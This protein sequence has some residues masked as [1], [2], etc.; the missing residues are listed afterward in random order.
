M[1]SL[2]TADVEWSFAGLSLIPFAG[3][4]Y[5]REGAVEFF[6]LVGQT[7]AFKQFEPREFIVQGGTVVVLGYERS[8]V[9]TTGRTL[10]KEWA[11]VYALRD[12]KIAKVRL[13]ENTAAL[14]CSS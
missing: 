6:S 1:L 2:L 12:G 11:H 3:T 7:L 14:V 5:G 10:E 9:K 13:I 4:R 8:Q